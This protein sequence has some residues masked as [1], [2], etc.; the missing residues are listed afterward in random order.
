MSEISRI[1][2]RLQRAFYGEAWH[3]PALMEVLSDIGADTAAAHP[4]SEA[5]SIWEIVL[6]LIAWNRALLVRMGG[7]ALELR[8][9]QDWPPVPK[10][11][12][13]EWQETVRALQNSYINLYEAIAKTPDAH[14]AETAPGK[15]YNFGFMFDGLADHFLYH[16]GQIALL[17]KASNR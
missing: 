10:F 14:L 3:G 6:H 16:A 17:K 1:T 11:S 4:L 8:R 2:D 15:D 12:D 7:R 9:S 5:H 13:T